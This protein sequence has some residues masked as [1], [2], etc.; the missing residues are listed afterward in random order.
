MLVADLGEGCPVEQDGRHGVQPVEHE[1]V[2][3]GGGQVGGGQGERCLVGPVDEPDP[4]EQRF[5]VIHVGV[6]D[7]TSCEQ[8]A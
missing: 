2:T 7:E 3:L 1:L 5:V 6:R 8:V 4:R